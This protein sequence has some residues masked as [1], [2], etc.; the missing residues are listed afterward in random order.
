MATSPQF[1][2]AAA[3]PTKVVRGVT[4]TTLFDLAA[5]YY[6]NALY[7]VQIAAANGLTDPW[8]SGPQDVVIPALVAQASPTGVM[9]P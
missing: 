1:F 5:A 2:V 3:P 4:F 7:W 6:G 9:A 8:I